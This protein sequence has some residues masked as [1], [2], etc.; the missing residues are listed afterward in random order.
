MHVQDS[1]CENQLQNN[2]FYLHHNCILYLQFLYRYI[3]RLAI[4]KQLKTKL[5]FSFQIFLKLI[6][7][8][9]EFPCT[10]GSILVDKRLAV[11]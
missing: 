6:P 1:Y 5:Y 8:L 3:D 2:L 7:L 9:I 4:P 11:I 10:N